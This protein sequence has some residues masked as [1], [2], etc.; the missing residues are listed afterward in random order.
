MSTDKVNDILWIIKDDSEIEY[1]LGV[2][3]FEQFKKDIQEL[4][5]K[6]VDKEPIQQAIEALKKFI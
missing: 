2:V 4:I 1:Y 3:T 6:S 5:K